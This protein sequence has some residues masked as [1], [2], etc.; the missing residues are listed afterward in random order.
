MCDTWFNVSIAVSQPAIN[1]LFLCLMLLFWLCL[2]VLSRSLPMITVSGP[3]TRQIRRNLQVSEFILLTFYHCI[4]LRRQTT[5]AFESFNWECTQLHRMIC[6]VCVCVCVCLQVR[7]WC[8]SALGKVFS[9]TPSRATMPVSLPMDRLVNYYVA[10][11]DM[12]MLYY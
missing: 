7:K 1:A 10:N 5:L 12:N 6:S 8:S 3:W 2:H 11:Y 9:V 4:V